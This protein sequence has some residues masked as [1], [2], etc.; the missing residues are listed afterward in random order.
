MSDTPVVPKRRITIWKILLGITLLGIAVMWIY[1]LFFAHYI[2]TDVIKDKAWS[3]GAESTCAVT[4]A[5]VNALPSANAFRNVTPRSD[6]IQQRADVAD[7]VTT[8]LRTMISNL[9]ANPSKDPA[10]VKLANFW[11]SEYDVYLSDRDAHVAQFRKGQDPPF[12]ETP[13]NRGAPGS[14]RMDTFVR[15][16][17]MP[18]CQVPL[19]LG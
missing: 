18:S 13:N 9:K 6:A 17:L 5:K 7:Q 15:L 10:T 2:S 4:K 14:V 1:A 19:D 11:L 8:E 16:N 12:A 3:A